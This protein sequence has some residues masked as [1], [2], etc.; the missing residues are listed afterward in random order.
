[1][2]SQMWSQI[3]SRSAHPVSKGSDYLSLPL[4]AINDFFENVAMTEHFNVPT[5]I[6]FQLVNVC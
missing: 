6:A 4:D 1:M 5:S 3:I 2:A